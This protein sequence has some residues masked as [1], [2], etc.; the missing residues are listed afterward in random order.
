MKVHQES[1]LKP[2][3]HEEIL[4]VGGARI[5]PGTPPRPQDKYGNTVSMEE[6]M[7][8]QLRALNE[9]GNSRLIFD[10]YDEGFDPHK[11][12]IYT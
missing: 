1:N 8:L 2:L 11:P 7:D 10:F 3:T 5:V 6:F 4:S 9:G 12:K